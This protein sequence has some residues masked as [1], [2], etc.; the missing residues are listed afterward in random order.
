MLLMQERLAK[1][2]RLLCGIKYKISMPAAQGFMIFSLRSKRFNW[3]TP[4]MAKRT[5]VP[6]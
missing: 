5:K 6:A 2:I 4:G 1:N 3:V